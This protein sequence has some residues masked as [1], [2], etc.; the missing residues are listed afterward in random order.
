MYTKVRPQYSIVREG[1]LCTPYAA[2][3]HLDLSA[4]SLIEREDQFRPSLNKSNTVLLL[5]CFPA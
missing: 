2:N 4:L 1:T 5:W 3:I